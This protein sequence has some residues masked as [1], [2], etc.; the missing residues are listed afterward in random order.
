MRNAKL[1]NHL[2]W[3]AHVQYVVA[4][5]AKRLYALM[6]LK[7]VGVMSKDIPKVYLCN[8]RS[9]LEYSAKVWQDILAYLSEPLNLY[10]E[11]L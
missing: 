10:K 6:L 2:K 4:K 9:V 3:N 5:A 1:G 11:E 7:R 8:V